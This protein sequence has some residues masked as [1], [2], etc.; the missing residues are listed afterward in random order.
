M[1]WKQELLWVKRNEHG[2]ALRIEEEQPDGVPVEELDSDSGEVDMT[3]TPLDSMSA[4]ASLNRYFAL[5]QYTK[6]TLKQA[7]DAINCLCQIYGAAKEE[8]LLER[9][10]RFN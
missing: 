9:G 5:I 4:F 8:V 6:P 2:V 7:E 3:I 10:F 1:N